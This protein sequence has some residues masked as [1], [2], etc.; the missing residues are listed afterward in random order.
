MQCRVSTMGPAGRAAGQWGM[1]SHCQGEAHPCAA[2]AV[3]GH[4]A[5]EA[6]RPAHHHTAGEQQWWPEVLATLMQP[7]WQGGW[8]RPHTSRKAGLCMPSYHIA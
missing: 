8:E 6:L 3:V 5:S 2:G 7:C 1:C 4:V